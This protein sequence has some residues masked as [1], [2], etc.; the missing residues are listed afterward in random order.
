M[1]FH[2]PFLHSYVNFAAF[3]GDIV[4]DDARVN[5][6]LVDS[7]P[8]DI[9]SGVGLDVVETRIVLVIHA[10]LA[11][12][13]LATVDQYPLGLFEGNCSHEI[14][15]VSAHLKAPVVKDGSECC[16]ADAG[17]E[18]HYS[19]CTNKSGNL[20]MTSIRVVSK[21]ML[22]MKQTILY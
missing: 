5:R 10:A 9:D 6:T 13:T 17:W 19:Y 2:Y 3:F 1:A 20:K 7:D 4:V 11:H 21:L 8:N 16:I 12:L 18:F 14:V 15:A 22:N